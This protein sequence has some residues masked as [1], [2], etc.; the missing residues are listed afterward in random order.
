MT[1][2]PVARLKDMCTGHDCHPPRPTTLASKNVFVNG[3]GWHRKGDTL[4]EHCCLL[5]CHP[6]VTTTGSSSVFV[7]KKP[8]AR[9]SDEVDCGSSIMT[10]S[11]N[12]F[13]G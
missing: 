7:N 9:V 13:A 11:G 12:V 2:M 4:E 1:G 10:G 3:R 8:A 6:G 5:S